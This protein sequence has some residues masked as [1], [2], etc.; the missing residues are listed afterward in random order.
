MI[1]CLVVL[2]TLRSSLAQ[3]PCFSIVG[4]EAQCA[5][6]K[7]TVRN[8][9]VGTNVYYI[10]DSSNQRFIINGRP[11]VDTIRYTQPGKYRLGQGILVG[12]TNLY[13]YKTIYIL[14]PRKP[15]PS[16]RACDNFLVQVQIPK[17]EGERFIITYGDGKQDTTANSMASVASLSHRYNGLAANPARINVRS[18]YNCGQDTTLTVP[19]RSALLGPDSVIVNQRGQTEIDVRLRSRIGYVYK[20]DIWVGTTYQT[21]PFSSIDSNNIRITNVPTGTRCFRLTCQDECGTTIAVIPFC[22]SFVRTNSQ[23]EY[24]QLQYGASSTPQTVASRPVEVLLTKNQ[25]ALLRTTMPTG[26]LVAGLTLRDSAITCKKQFCYALT[27]GYSYPYGSGQ[28]TQ[29][30]ITSLRACTLGRSA[31]IPPRLQTLTVTKI[32][33]LSRLTWRPPTNF[34]VK[35]YT[36]RRYLNASTVASRTDT[37]SRLTYFDELNETTLRRHFYTLQYSDSCGNVSAES[38][39]V[40]G[41]V[42]TSTGVNPAYTFIKWSEY[43]GWPKV[44]QRYELQLLNKM[45]DEVIK[46]FALPRDTNVYELRERI[47]SSQLLRFRIKIVPDTNIVDTAY[48]NI[49]E[50]RQVS[51]ILMPNAFSPND[52]KI[53]DLYLVQAQFMSEF[54]I[55]IMNRW[56]LVVYEGSDPNLG[57]DGLVGGSRAPIDVYVAIVTG[58][59]EFGKAI[60]QTQM[61]TLIR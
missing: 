2:A 1:I 51:G 33:M 45:T 28:S 9:V 56:G 10:P 47:E 48:S 15:E 22:M 40:A 41:T 30:R 34:A 59:D 25:V 29:L 57:W 24:I 36:I 61:V 6:G 43:L 17:I 39:R 44:P 60:S 55:R 46:T 35:Y 21:H 14:Q 27:Y 16:V 26:S 11:G 38:N 4:S 20:L 52:D 37:T 53:N 50:V 58:K 18:L 13:T 8:C 12:G 5:P 54:S 19:L 3:V 31:K 42:L 32:G 7:I 23:N 49:D